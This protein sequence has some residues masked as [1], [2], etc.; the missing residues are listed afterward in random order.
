M[1]ASLNEEADFTAALAES[2]HQVARRVKRETFSDPS[3]EIVKAALDRLQ[4]SLREILPSGG[5]AWSSCR[6]PMDPEMQ[7]ARPHRRPN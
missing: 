6:N 1:V 3:K 4:Y 7:R 5:L 2:L